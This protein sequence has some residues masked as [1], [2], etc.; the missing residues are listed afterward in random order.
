MLRDADILLVR[1]H[2]L[3]LAMALP[4]E[5]PIEL[6]V[7]LSVPNGE[8]KHHVVLLLPDGKGL[9]AGGTYSGTRSRGTAIPPLPKG[10]LRTAFQK[11]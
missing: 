9:D 1:G 5:Q 11:Q 6:R 4:H 8:D 2:R 7:A 3:Q 10:L